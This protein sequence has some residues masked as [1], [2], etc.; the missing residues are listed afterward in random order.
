MGRTIP[1]V[2]CRLDSRLRKWEK[3]G[4]LLG[5]EERRA[6]RELVALARNRRT[7]IGEADEADIGV[8][9]LLAMATHLKHESKGGDA[10]SVRPRRGE[11]S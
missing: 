11:G 9:I 10:C 2:T 3:F 4:R 8:A 6:F 5:P 7:A 1:S